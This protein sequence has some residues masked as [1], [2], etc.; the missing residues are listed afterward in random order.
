MVFERG[1]FSVKNGKEKG[2]GVWASGRSLPVEN[3]VGYDSGVVL[4]LY[5]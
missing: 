4:F 3:F 2:E 5:T 1:T